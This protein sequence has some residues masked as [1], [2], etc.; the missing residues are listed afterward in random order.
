MNYAQE[1]CLIR[2]RFG[3]WCFNAG[4]WPTLATFALLPLLIGLGLWQLDRAEQKQRLQQ[5]YDA[6]LTAPVVP[7]TGAEP[8]LADI[9]YRRVQARGRYD[10]AQEIL[11]D[12]RVYQGQAGYHVLTPLQISGSAQRVLVNRGWVATGRDRRE[13]PATP[14]PETDVVVE[15]VAVQPS[16]PGL[17]LGPAFAE[18]EAWPVVWQYLEL[19]AYARRAGVT[20][21][22]MVILLDTGSPAG[23]FV[24]QW[25]RLD[26][27]IATHQGYALT[28]FSL[29]TVLLAIYILL[30]LRRC[31]AASHE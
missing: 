30:N 5:H 25:A 10:T 7:L 4:L 26:A 21:Y 11:L 22:P 9:K 31:N 29:A 24:R 18:G 20:V 8:K 27:G 19:E 1:Q 3:N 2:L 12:N 14:A 13:R 23:G 17:R 15:G 16:A 28:W 6:G